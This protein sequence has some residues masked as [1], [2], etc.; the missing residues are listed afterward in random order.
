MR[1]MKLKAALFALLLAAP[2][3]LAQNGTVRIHAATVLDGT[4]KTLRNATI[5]V[6]GSKITSIETGGAA[7][8]NYELGQL[9][10]LP[11]LIDVHAHVGWHF[12][13]DGRYANRPGSPAQEI[14][15]SAENAYVTLLAGFTTIQS[16][17]QANDVELREGIARGVFPGPRILTS[18]RQINERSGTPDEIRQKVRQLKTDGADVIKIFA[19]ASIR[20]GGKQT[21][22]D[23]QIAAV[24]GEANAQGMRTM[25]HAHSPESIKAS[26]NAGCLQIEHGVFATDEVLKL[27]ADKGVYFDP[28][29]GVVLQN[30][31][32]NRD[33]YNGIGNY[34]DEGFA[35]MEKGLGLNKTMIKKAVATPKLMMVLGTDAV[36]GAHGHNA[37]EI[38]E[39]VR[40]GGQ[41]PM[42]AIISATSMAAKSMRLEKTIGT[43][44]AGYEAD[45]VGVDGDPL[46]DIT[47]VTRVA[48]VMKGGKVYKLETGT[49]H[50]SAPT[51]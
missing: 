33:K 9:T 27:M 21:M 38:V 32:K 46:T 17:G 48:F 47:A 11:G 20:D 14:L 18:I 16:P 19:S 49:A 50:V 28:N 5:V 36:A 35:Y 24:C 12:D 39:R 41:K 45:I 43:L 22:T 7:N 4:G 25:V 44:A 42:D 37:D 1:A 40:Q 3:L 13:K 34:N 23:E 29:V 51:R 15:Y 8:A 6:Q 26:V 30:Y 10:V 2:T 31:L